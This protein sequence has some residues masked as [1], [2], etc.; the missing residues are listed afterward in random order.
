[1]YPLRRKVAAMGGMS[2]QIPIRNDPK[3]NEVAMAKV[4]AD[5]L[6]EVTAGHDGT[7]IAHPLIN[8]IARQIFDEHM[9]GPNQVRTFLRRVTSHCSL[10]D[11]CMKIVPSAP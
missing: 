10:R 9:L 6:R 4:R 8:Q 7:W 3:A 11:I 5:K 2:A 1:M